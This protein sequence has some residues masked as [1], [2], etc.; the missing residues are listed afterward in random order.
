MLG[1][2]N[3]F[4]EQK[5][6]ILKKVKVDL[7]SMLKMKGRSHNDI[8]EYLNAFDYFILNPKKYDGATIVKDLVD[9]R[10]GSR[11][12]DLDAML[13]DYEYIVG[14][15]RSFHKKWKSD[16]RYIKGMELNGKG[17]RIPRLILLTILGIIFVPYK[18]IQSW[19][20]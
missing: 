10:I 20:G 16:V 15:N 12:L 5:L 1:S 6:N 18:I 17:I 14:A 8:G 9:I 11:Y 7:V 19:L 2:K 13:H 3:N 4:F